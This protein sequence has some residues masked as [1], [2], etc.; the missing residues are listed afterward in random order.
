MAQT[1]RHSTYTDGG[2]VDLDDEV[3]IDSK[4]G[5]RITESDAERLADEAEKNGPGRPSLGES[6]RSPIIT[7]RVAKSTKQRLADFSKQTQR[8]PSDVAREALEEYLARHS[9]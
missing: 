7:Y 1:K 3:L 2:S 9:G 6:G 5:E 8:R 4:T